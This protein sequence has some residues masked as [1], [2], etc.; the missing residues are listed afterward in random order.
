M[1]KLYISF[2]PNGVVRDIGPQGDFV[3]PNKSTLALRYA[4][5]DGKVV[6]QY[7]GKSDDEVLDLIK[8]QQ[9]S[10]AAT[11]HAA[12]P[13]HIDKLEFLRRFT[14]EE[15][16]ALRTAQKKPMSSRQI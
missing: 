3:L 13:K 14:R 4:L 8:T 11:A 15:R 5:V 16:V 1:P 6:D 9:E 2:H 10:E 7:I 12:M